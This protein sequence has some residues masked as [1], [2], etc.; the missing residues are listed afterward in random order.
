MA[1]LPHRLDRTV[2]IGAPRE[3]VFRFFT[4]EARWASWWGKGSTIDPRPG[5]NILLVYPGDVR[6]AGQV[7]DIAPPHRIVFTYGFVSGKPIPPGSSRVSIELEPIAGGTRLTL[8]HAFADAAVRDEHV[9]GWRYQLS[10]FANLVADVVHAGAAD[11]IDRW[12]ALWAEPDPAARQAALAAIADDGVRF[13]DRYSRVEGRDDLLPHIAAAQRFMP[14]MRMARDGNVRH[15]QGLVLA[16]FTMTG[17]DGV[18][19][20]KGTNVFEFGPDGK[21]L[22]VTGFW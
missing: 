21:I 12:L 18:V 16:D 5:G 10:L 14:G 6:A 3:T 17:P 11:R 7:V 1:D 22:R 15:C 2:V 20:G 19:K 8:V 13:G 4:D 9:Q